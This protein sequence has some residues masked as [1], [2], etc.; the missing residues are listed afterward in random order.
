METCGNCATAASDP[1]GLIGS[2]DSVPCNLSSAIL[3][4]EC[5]RAL[6]HLRFGR[7]YSEDTIAARQQSLH[8]F[9]ERMDFVNIT[10]TV[11]HRAA[12]ASRVLREFRRPPSGEA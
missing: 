8:E 12:Q 10:D 9:I 4:V 7:G 6:D 11:L 2:H 1:G 5:F 3:R